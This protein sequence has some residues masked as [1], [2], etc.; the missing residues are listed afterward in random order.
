MS[1]SKKDIILLSSLAV[2]AASA[3]IAKVFFL[4]EK[5]TSSEDK[6]AESIVYDSEGYDPDGYDR[7]GYN[8]Q[9]FNREGYD[10][11]GYN[12]EGFNIKGFDRS[13][14]DQFGFNSKGLDKDGF[15]KS[16]SDKLGLSRTD[17]QKRLELL[18]KRW[19]KAYSQMESGEFEYALYDSRLVME[20]TLRLIVFHHIGGRLRDD[21]SLN[22][23]RYCQKNK[24]LDDDMI[25]RLHD[26]RKSGNVNNH[27]LLSGQS[28][29]PKKI[30]FVLMQVRDLL[31]EAKQLLVNT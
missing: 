11:S 12:L 26:V 10:R 28:I 5:Y 31:T 15:D 4:D 20:E 6:E 25:D 1:L 24:Y 27:D 17:Y 3:V 9:G 16:G 18:L 13:G 14:Y 7:K 29:S 30:Y 21:S 2:S 8:R 23:L 19:R 22:L